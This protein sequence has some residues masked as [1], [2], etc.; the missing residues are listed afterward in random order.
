MTR[1]QTTLPYDIAT[2]VKGLLTPKPLTV[3]NLRGAAHAAEMYQTYGPHWPWI[4]YVHNSMN[5]MTSS[6]RSL[7]IIKGV[8]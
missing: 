4:E 8:E 3:M 2:W 7:T 6:P 5:A 1:I